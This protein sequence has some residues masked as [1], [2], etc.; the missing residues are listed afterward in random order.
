[1]E[2]WT[3]PRGSR[4]PGEVERVCVAWT[5]PSGVEMTPWGWEE[6]TWGWAGLGYCRGREVTFGNRLKHGGPGQMEHSLIW[7]LVLIHFLLAYRDGCKQGH[8]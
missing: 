8:S 6:R 4:E 7:R 5:G 3:G 2:G 1:M